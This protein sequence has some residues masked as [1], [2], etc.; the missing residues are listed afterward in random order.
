MPAFKVMRLPS[1]WEIDQSCP[2]HLFST[3]TMH[4]LYSLHQQYKE[5]TICA[6]KNACK[7]SCCQIQDLGWSNPS[8]NVGDL[9]DG[10]L[11]CCNSSLVLIHHELEDFSDFCVSKPR[12]G[13]PKSYQRILADCHRPNWTERSI[14]HHWK[15]LQF[16]VDCRHLFFE[17]CEK[18]ILFMS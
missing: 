2:K 10:L 4:L 13:Y 18:I 1:G 3:Q 5:T 15:A 9:L 16:N 7:K 17:Y 14:F 6:S 8:S 12:S 11:A